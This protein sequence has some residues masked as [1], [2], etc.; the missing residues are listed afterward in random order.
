MAAN[1]SQSA[2]E[3]EP[4]SQEGKAAEIER[5]L[6]S[7][8]FANAPMKRRFLMLICEFHLSG[9][10]ADL[11]EYLIGREVFDRNESYNPATDPI[12]R[13][14]AH[15][16]REKLTLYYQTEGAANEIRIE[17]PIGS[18]EPVFIL[19]KTRMEYADPAPTLEPLRTPAPIIAAI[20]PAS[21]AATRKSSRATWAMFAGL[22]LL[23][24]ALVVLLYNNLRLRKEI[25]ATA[26]GSMLAKKQAGLVWSR[27]L[28]SPDP[29]MLILS[30]PM[31]HRALNTAD[32]EGLAKKSILLSQEQAAV[33]TDAMGNRLPLPRDHSLQLIPAFNMYTGI[34]E[35]VGVY[36]ISSLLHAAGETTILKQSRSISPDDLKSFDAILLGSVYA[37]QWSKPLSIRENF[38]YTNRSTIENLAPR[39]GEEREYRAA[40]NPETNSLIEDH[41][42]VTVVPG[43]LGERMV[44]VIAG[45]Y[46]EGT[47]A[48]AD[49]ISSPN[50][51][52]EL[53]RRLEK[54]GGSKGPPQYFQALLK[55]RVENSFPTKTTLV[56]V[57][58]LQPNGQ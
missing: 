21:P 19:N 55:V 34:G 14:G 30:N 32:P 57:R 9:R 1:T 43:V 52:A 12:V 7:K 44:M 42:L 24:S 8:Y 16:I 45:I 15:G 26:V 37:N 31:V 3:G 18:Y 58:E 17:I 33:L 5:V 27:F 50:H 20:Q 41:A 47:E 35:A 13:V 11:N 56:T 40:F 10:G 53:N 22:V 46:S 29:T 25:E 4:L 54:M 23:S 49:Y 36:R 51:L 38:I 48:A 2:R 39:P 6:G 28:Q